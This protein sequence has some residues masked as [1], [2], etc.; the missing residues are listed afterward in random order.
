LKPKEPLVAVLL[1]LVY[2]GLG[3]IYAGAKKRGILFLSF[4]TGITII[5]L[6]YVILPNTKLFFWMLLP[7]S[8]LLAFG[9]FIIIDAYRCATSWN[10][11]NGFVQETTPGN[12]IALFVGIFFLVFVFNPSELAS[13][14]VRTNVVQAFKI[15][16][17]AMV[18]TLLKGDRILVDKGIYRREEPR[19][20]DIAV[21][22]SP[23][24]AEKSYIKRVAGLPGE[25]LE[26]RDG[27]LF[28]NG[29]L[30]NQDPFKRIS[31]INRGSY[32]EA[33]KQ[34]VIPAGHY[35]LLGDNGSESLDSR[36]FGFIPRKSLLGKAYKIYFPFDRSGP[37]E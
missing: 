4:S 26:I 11:A 19:R 24:K 32:G 33:G 6:S 15:P 30:L 22:S 8:F 28:V 18:P 13:L 35:Y 10:S 7:V 17:E 9:I 5:T 21:F 34:V 16:T 12:K 20:G 25:T 14:Y 1:S 31:Y 23:D 36:Y 29:S 27:H 2:P 3:Q 37:L